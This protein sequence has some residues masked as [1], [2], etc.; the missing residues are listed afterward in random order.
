MLNVKCWFWVSSL[1]WLATGF[2]GTNLWAQQLVFVDFD[3]E[4]TFG[5]HIYTASERQQIMDEIE[6]DYARFL[7]VFTD[8]EPT[9]IAHSTVTLNDGPAF[10]IA[11]AVDFRNL[12]MNDNATVNVNSGA[13]TSAQFVTLTANVLSHELGHLLGL[14]HG[15]SF[16][17]IGSGVDSNTVFG[18]DFLPSFLGPQDAF[19][20]QFHLQESDGVFVEDVVNQFFSERSAIRLTFNEIGTVIS[21]QPGDKSTLATAQTIELRNMI[22]PNTIE[23]GDRASLGDFDVD[24]LVVTGSLS[25]AGQV[26]L[27][28]IEAGAGALL[29]IEVISDVISDRFGFES[30]DPQLTVL[31]DTGNPVDYYGAPA[32]NDDE[33]ESFDSILIDLI[34]PEDGDYFIQVNAFS[35][36]DTG[37]Y[38]L[39]VNQFNGVAELGLKGDFDDDNDVDIVDVDFYVG[40][41]GSAATGELAQLDLSGDGQILFADLETHVTVCVQTSNG[42]TGTFLGD[43]NLDGAVNVLGDAFILV[44]SLGGSATSY[45]QGDIDLDGTVDVLRDAFILVGN[46]GSSNAPSNAP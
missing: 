45:G 41:I 15:D 42:Q 30:I 33:F 1:I 22:V 37:S 28:R 39:F 31:D 20:T 29:N 3:S 18:T 14:R 43:L 4:T 40:N 46:L 7:V 21:E 35:S 2:C 27:Y 36:F 34:L 12:N 26:D 32:F 23:V 6:N 9:G 24:A 44:G 38:E 10:G 13:T 17:P 5:E 8:T 19:E 11:E 25:T 16:G